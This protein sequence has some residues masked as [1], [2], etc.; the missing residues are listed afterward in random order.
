MRR[1]LLAIG[2]L[3]AAALA[4]GSAAAGT[5]PPFYGYAPYYGGPSVYFTPEEDVR[6]ASTI[7]SGLPGYGTRTFY[8]GGPFYRYKPVYGR[9]T[10]Y[11]RRARSRVVLRRRG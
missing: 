4:S 2:M 9:P 3:A 5:Y 10:Y 6:S 7:S 1:G 8:R 11:P